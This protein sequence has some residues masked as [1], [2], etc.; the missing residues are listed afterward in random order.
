MYIRIY[1]T[2]NPGR[3]A[4]QKNANEISKVRCWVSRRVKF[5]V[6]TNGAAKGHNCCISDL[7]SGLSSGAIGTVS[8]KPILTMM[9]TT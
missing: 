7:N 9:S 6:L 8:K 3:T 2:A 1:V 4:R 5:F